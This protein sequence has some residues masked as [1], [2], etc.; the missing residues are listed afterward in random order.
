M[1][2]T[3][4]MEKILHRARAPTQLSI[5]LEKEQLFGVDDVALVCTK[6][7]L[8]DETLIDCCGKSGGCTVRFPGRE[9]VHQKSLGFVQEAFA[10][11]RH[12]Q[13]TSQTEQDDKA[14]PDEVKRRIDGQW[15]ACHGFVFK[16]FRLLSETQQNKI[17]RMSHGAPRAFPIVN[18][19]VFCAACRTVSLSKLP[20]LQRIRTRHG[21]FLA[22]LSCG[23]V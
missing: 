17:Y 10:T 13:P 9:G 18:H 15:E 3:P 4:E 2:L 19:C 6:E 7:E 14:L 11:W 16:T 1:K 8:L 5:F 22:C 20:P 21:R 12:G 23:P